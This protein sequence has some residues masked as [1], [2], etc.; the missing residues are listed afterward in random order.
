MK[1]LIAI[2]ILILIFIIGLLVFDKQGTDGKVCFEKKCFSVEVV[3]TPAS[4][5]VGLMNRDYLAPNR[6]M[7]FVFETAGNYPFWMKN[8]LIPL[9][10][11]WIS[12]DK[13]VVYVAHDSQP[14]E[15]DPCPI[16]RHNG[17]AKYVLEINTGLAS[18]NEID[19]GDDIT[20]SVNI[21]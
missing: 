16:I 5:E 14:C 9:D 7:L 19:V 10:M 15:A 6:G 21:A 4:R 12:E 11:I 18:E 2:F 17:T 13:K 20:L 3:D 8:T 1:Y